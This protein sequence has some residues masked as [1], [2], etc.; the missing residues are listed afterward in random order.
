MSIF[1]S[2]EYQKQV[3]E[4]VEEKQTATTKTVTRI[5]ETKVVKTR[6]NKGQNNASNPLNWQTVVGWLI[7]I[8]AI[9][10]AIIIG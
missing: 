6:K 3:K 8:G 4:T 9:I 2:N 5:T 7:G 10:A 1:K